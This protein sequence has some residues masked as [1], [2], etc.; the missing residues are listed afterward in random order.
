MLVAENECTSSAPIPL[1]TVAPPPERWGII[2]AGGEGVRLRPLTR[3]ISG[4]DLPKQ[5][6]PVLGPETLLQQAESR[7]RRSIP[8]ERIIVA[9]TTT[10]AA[11]YQGDLEYSPPRRL[12][13]P[14]NRGTAPAIILSLFHIVEQDPDA[15]VAVL[16][17]DHY[18]SNEAAF[19]GS[20]ESAFQAARNNPESLV[21]LGAKPD[22]PEIE[23]DWIQLGPAQ[24]KNLYRVR[25]FEEKP[26][27]DAAQRLLNSGALWNTFVTVGRAV[28][29]LWLSLAGV[30]ELFAELAN[31]SLDCDEAGDL[32]VPSSLYSAIPAADFSRQVLSPNAFRLLAMPLNAQQWQDLGQPHRV[33]SP[34]QSREDA[35]PR[36]VQAWDAAQRAARRYSVS[37]E[38][39]SFRGLV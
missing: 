7:A 17:C 4:D 21:L 19:T 9:L 35:P 1:Q 6:C 31:A 34:M 10:H 24:G 5:F 27:P 33:L 18:Y 12:L 32:H 20:L 3:L 14:F 11:Y 37:R 39:S 8:E 23:F 15:I 30:P 13:Q 25:A 22:R 29:F 16:P 2:L 28:A 38:R 36:W 26:D